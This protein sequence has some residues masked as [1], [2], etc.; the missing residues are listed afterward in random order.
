MGKY[1]VLKEGSFDKTLYKK[2]VNKKYVFVSN[3]AYIASCLQNGIIVGGHQGK[4]NIEIYEDQLRCKK[5]ASIS[6]IV[7]PSVNKKLPLFVNRWNG[8]P[9]E[10][11]PNNLIEKPAGQKYYNLEHS[12]LICEEAAEA[13]EKMAKDAANKANIH[14][15]VSYAYRSYEEQEKLIEELIKINGETETK[16]T[17]APAGFS[18][19]HTG[20]AIDVSGA[21]RED[22]TH[23]TENED[24]YKWIANNCHKYGF[25]IK[26]LEGKEHIT[27]TKYEPWHIR[28]IGDLEV[29]RYLYE[30]NFTL[31]EFLLEQCKNQSEQSIELCNIEEAEYVKW[32][33]NDCG[34]DIEEVIKIFS[35]AKEKYNIPFSYTYKNKLYNYSEKT[36]V[37]QAE[38][39][40]NEINNNE[41]YY[42]EIK[43]EIGLS[44]QDIDLNIAIIN[45]NP[46]SKIDLAQYAQ[47]KFYDM[48]N[49]T[50]ND[51]LMTIQQR[52]ILAKK[53]STLFK[54]IDNG[55]SRYKE[56]FPLI[57]EYYDVT[58][59][60]LLESDIDEFK[61]TIEKC[62]PNICN[63]REE[64]VD[65]V[66]DMLVCKRLMGFWPF[67]YFMFELPDK[68]IEER[69]RYVSNIDRTSKISKV[70]DRVQSEFLDNKFLTYHVLNEFYKR[71][72]VMIES[73]ND[74]QPFKDFVSKHKTFVKKPVN[75]SMGSGIGLVEVSEEEDTYDL[76][77]RIIDDVGSFEAEEVIVAHERI[78]KLNP[79]SV[80]TIRMST[81]Y[82]NGKVHILWPWMKVGRAGSFVDNS[83]SGGMG[84]AIDIET[85]KLNSS[86]KD[87]NGNVF[88]KHPDTG[89]IFK[90]YE[91][92]DWESAL[93]F[94]KRISTAL[95]SRI[96]GINFV[97]WDIT[98]TADNEW[99]VVEGNAFPQFVQQ[100]TYNY[101]FKKELNSIIK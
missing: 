36:V 58:K 49:D 4:V 42:Q 66:V 38:K 40:L 56:V 35:V 9:K 48:D 98:Y 79:D 85:G 26:N 62:A 53:I 47:L 31:D 19:H 97:G 33:A 8:L 3:N 10:Y 16:H 67:E 74:Y 64:L 18:E 30:K 32:A 82:D 22:G 13:Y 69:R 54:K 17:A 101:G 41:R 5:I 99:V 93:D 100:A 89:L 75:G 28:Y 50:I 78:K 61:E 94:G 59:K 91:L 92:P 77:K 52:R 55:L 39:R 25:M 46:Y 87:E 37:G 43:K 45:E 1:I 60:S 15:K 90:G 2:F 71:D 95:A 86:G 44:K 23:I 73:M 7:I 51:M 68:S 84:V 70:N 96:D 57:S 21:I 14:L 12:I 24:A 65:V 29:T 88:D 81:L 72:M 11:K 80:N 83:G 27:G 63:N 6:I 20:L 34:R 76:L